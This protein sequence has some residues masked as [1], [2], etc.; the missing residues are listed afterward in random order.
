VVKELA[1]RYHGDL[2]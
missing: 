1:P 2:K